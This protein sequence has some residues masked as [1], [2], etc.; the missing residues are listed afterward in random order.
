M[1]LLAHTSVAAGP[2]GLVARRPTSPAF[3]LTRGAIRLQVASPDVA[4]Q[5]AKN[6]DDRGFALKP[7]RLWW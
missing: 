3:R 7:V 6:V 2:S 4:Q 1:A 5:P